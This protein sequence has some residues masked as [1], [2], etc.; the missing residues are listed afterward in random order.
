MTENKQTLYTH[1][2]KQQQNNHL[3]LNLTKIYQTFKKIILKLYWNTA[4]KYK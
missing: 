4:N 3:G 1:K 2:S